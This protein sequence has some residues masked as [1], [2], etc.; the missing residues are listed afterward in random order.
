MQNNIR[1]EPTELAVLKFLNNRMD[2]SDDF[3]RYYFN[4]QKGYDGERMFD[5]LTESLQSECLILNDLL[6]EINNTVF[7]IDTLIIFP[8]TIYIFDVKNYEGIIITNPVTYT[9]KTNLK[10]VIR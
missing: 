5:S 6:L 10:L 8:E 1:K 9:Q 7:Q 3:K 2:L 4:L